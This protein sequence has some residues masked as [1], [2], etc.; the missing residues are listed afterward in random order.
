MMVTSSFAFN[1]A[2]SGKFAKYSIIFVMALNLENDCMNPKFCMECNHMNVNL[3]FIAF[4]RSNIILESAKD[5][6]K[7]FVNL[8][9][10]LNSY[11]NTNFHVFFDSLRNFE[12]FRI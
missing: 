4:S 9:L 7:I 11:S 1:C 12:A 10:S 2:I 5:K 6:I 8:R 3:L